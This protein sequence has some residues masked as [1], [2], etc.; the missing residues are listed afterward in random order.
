M[1]FTKKVIYQDYFIPSDSIKIPE[2]YIIGKQWTSVIDLLRLNKIDFKYFK[3]DTIINIE[4]YKIASYETVKNPYEGHYLHYKTQTKA[5]VSQQ[6]VYTGDVLIPTNQLGFKYLLET[7]EPSA[8]DS[9]F[10]WNFFD[11]IL[12]QKEGFSPYVFEDTALALLQ[13]NSVLRNE[14]NT[15]KHIEKEFSKNWYSQLNWLFKRSKHYEKVHMQ[16][17]VF[18]ILKPE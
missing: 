17:R 6:K 15:K 2:A 8:A 5:T 1:P 13:N 7:L 11:T 4:S 18:R 16:Y 14:F 3:K 10:N 9:F 12:Q